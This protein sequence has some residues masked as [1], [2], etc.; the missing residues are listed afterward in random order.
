MAKAS[1]ESTVAPSTSCMTRRYPRIIHRKRIID[2]WNAS[3]ATVNKMTGYCF[4][5]TWA[6]F[7]HSTIWYSADA[8]LIMA[9]NIP[10]GDS[11]NKQASVS[12]RGPNIL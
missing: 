6:A 3:H 5:Y 8:F 2:P 11:N 1:K 9:V 4:C 10:G 7:D 12:L